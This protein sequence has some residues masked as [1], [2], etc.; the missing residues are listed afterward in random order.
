MLYK[1]VPEIKKK[2]FKI[3][4]YFL[5]NNYKFMEIPI[6][7]K[8]VL[9]MCI[10][11][12]SVNK[13]Y[14]K[15]CYEDLYYIS[16]QKPITIKTKNSISNFS[17]KKGFK[18]SLK[19]TLRKNNMYEF[20]NKLI[21]ISIPRIKDFNGF[22]LNSFDYFGNYNIGIKDHN[23]FPEI[24]LKKKITSPK[25]LDININIKNKNINDSYILLKK[26]NFPFNV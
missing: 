4:N 17:I 20:L 7:N 11:N 13:K 15:E 26:L 2:Y 9:N 12:R 5:K 19:V 16:M 8:V 10:G 22:S 18:I 14:M 23:I 25:G 24:F 6:I 3:V 21:N 1:Y